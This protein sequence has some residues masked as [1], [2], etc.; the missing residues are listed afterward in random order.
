MEK[1]AFIIATCT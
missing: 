1:A